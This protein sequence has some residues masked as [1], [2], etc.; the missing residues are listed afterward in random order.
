MSNKEN[1]RSFLTEF[2]EI[3]RSFC[4]QRNSEAHLRLLKLQGSAS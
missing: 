4:V 2:C 3:A 1:K